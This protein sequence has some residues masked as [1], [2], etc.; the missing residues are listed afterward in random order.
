VFVGCVVM[1]Q[2]KVC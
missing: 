1:Q 2:T